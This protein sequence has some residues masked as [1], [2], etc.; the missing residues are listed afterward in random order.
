MK[1][2]L[3]V[4]ARPNFMKVYPLFKALESKAGVQT[5]LVHTGQHADE[6]MS[7]IFFQQFQLPEPN[8]YLG[9]SGGTHVTMLAGILLAFENVLRIEN[10]NVVVV[11]G[12]VNST[13]A[14]A[15]TAAKLNIPVA[16][17][18]AGLRSFDRDMP[19]E[20]NRII[21]DQL[22]TYL[23]TTE[24]SANTNL[25]NEGIDKSKIHFVGNC[26]IDCL[27]KFLPS[28]DSASVRKKLV[29]DNTDYA[30]MT[31][32]RPSNVD[33]EAGLKR[34][35]DLC[36]VVSKKIHLVFTI[37]PRT[38]KKLEQFGLWDQLQKNDKI[39]TTQPL[40]YLE[41][42][43]LMKESSV[44]LTDSGGIQEET[45]FLNIPCLTFRN[46]TERPVTIDEGTNIL[47]TH[48]DLKLTE[49]YIVQIL[50]NNWKQTKVPELWDGQAA[51]RIVDYLL[52][53]H[54]S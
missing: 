10:P 49:E 35:I 1:I 23:F 34:I 39:I 11:V 33:T 6:N 40:G 15:L 53:Y 18:E 14:C 8:Y 20:I 46:T 51:L 44:V 2:I 45:T 29:I 7:D 50:Q 41:F 5:I 24:S 52:T 37:H 19:E 31:M 16:H 3:I 26:M 4:G 54:Q 9:I 47:V 28:A 17:V 36:N 25:L 13:L 43:G 21:T 30:V 38:S 27:L 32:H 48:F 42:L 22:S 12:D